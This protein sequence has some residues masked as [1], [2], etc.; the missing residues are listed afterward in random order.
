MVDSTQNINLELVK[1]RFKKGIATYDKHARVQQK[2][3]NSLIKRLTSYLNNSPLD[4][5]EI[6]CGTG[7][8]TRE[9]VKYF[10]INNII[11]NDLIEEVE[12][13]IQIILSESN[14]YDTQF[15]SGDINTIHFP[16][17]KNLVVSG[18]T[19]QWISDIDNFL[20]KASNSLN[21]NGILAFSTFGPSNFIEIRK[22][23]KSGLDY[24]S[25]EDFT[26][27]TSKRFTT[28]HMEEWTETLL[29]N[30]PAEVLKHI[31]YTGVGG[32]TI[33][34]WTKNKLQQFYSAYEQYKTIGN[35]YPLTYHPQLIILK[36]KS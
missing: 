13:T 36:K 21:D 35:K 20:F 29:F 2:M 30:S 19:L 26:I 22:I 34:R 9:I 16:Q 31:Q 14:I 12:P 24:H 1:Q 25:L 15:I 3:A 6:G 11:I 18:A 7:L 33:Q 17:N 27:Y 23:I 5:F 4:I 10:N 32:L 8:L 28:L